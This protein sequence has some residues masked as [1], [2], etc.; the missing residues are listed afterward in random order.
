MSHL[1]TRNYLLWNMSLSIVQSYFF[2]SHSITLTS[3]QKNIPAENSKIILKTHRMMKVV[4]N[5]FLVKSM[6]SLWNEFKQNKFQTKISSYNRPVTICPGKAILKDT[7]LNIT[8]DL[9]SWQAWPAVFRKVPKMSSWFRLPTVMVA[10]RCT[11]SVWSC[12]FFHAT[13]LRLAWSIKTL[14][15]G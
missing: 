2:A 7:L 3:R 9:N 4:W 13:G 11:C 14:S 12:R 8:N 1:T 15:D 5:T 10:S 6:I